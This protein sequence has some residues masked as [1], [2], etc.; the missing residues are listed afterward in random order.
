MTKKRVKNISDIQ[1]LT[2]ST[3][4][5]EPEEASE[6]LVYGS[7][8]TRLIARENFKKIYMP[9]RLKILINIFSTM[10]MGAIRSFIKSKLSPDYTA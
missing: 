1:W 5:K 10:K 9:R 2:T 8:L 3:L 7:T 6:T 4:R